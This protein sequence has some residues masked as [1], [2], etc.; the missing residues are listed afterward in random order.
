MGN[1]ETEMKRLAL[2][3]SS[4]W[5]PSITIFLVVVGVLSALVS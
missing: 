2:P 3:A 5:I 4:W 1:Y